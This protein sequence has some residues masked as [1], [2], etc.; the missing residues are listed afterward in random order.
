[1]YAAA[2]GARARIHLGCICAPRA[3]RFGCGT[4]RQPLT[5]ANRNSGK[6]PQFLPWLN[7]TK[8]SSYIDRRA[9]LEAFRYAA[10]GAAITPLPIA[11]G[12]RAELTPLRRTADRRL[13]Q[14]LDYTPESLSNRCQCRYSAPNDAPVQFRPP[15]QASARPRQ[16][17]I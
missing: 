2:S 10:R 17:K 9:R 14:F 13:L 1:M 11:N 8:T 12:I 6:S 16:P 15:Q 4:V 3:Q 7:S 5:L